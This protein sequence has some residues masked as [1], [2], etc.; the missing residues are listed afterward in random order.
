MLSLAMFVVCGNN[1]ERVSNR[2]TEPI[3]LKIGL[4]MGT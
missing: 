2:S 1:F 3:D 4:N